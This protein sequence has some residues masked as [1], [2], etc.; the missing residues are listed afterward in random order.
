MDALLAPIEQ[1]CFVVPHLAPTPQRLLAMTQSQSA[2]TDSG[3]SS[4]REV[5]RYHGQPMPLISPPDD[6]AISQPRIQVLPC[7]IHVV[8]QINLVLP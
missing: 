8:D 3:D 4:L 6:E 2:A 5:W 7:R 1:D